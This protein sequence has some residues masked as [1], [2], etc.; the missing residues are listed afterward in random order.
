MLVYQ[1]I[2]DD[3][4]IVMTSYFNFYKSIFHMIYTLDC[5]H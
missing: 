4:F 2:I 5:K 3:K 1:I